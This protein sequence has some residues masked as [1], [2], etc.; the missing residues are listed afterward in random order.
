MTHQDQPS[1]FSSCESDEPN[2]LSSPSDSAC[3][4]STI[5]GYHIVRIHRRDFTAEELLR[6]ILLSHQYTNLPEE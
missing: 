2:L 5:Q 1:V 4:S 3:S 6:R